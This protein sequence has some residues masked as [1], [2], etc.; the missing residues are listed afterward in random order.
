LVGL[1]MAPRMFTQGGVDSDVPL[2]GRADFGAAVVHALSSM[3]ASDLSWLPFSR[4]RSRE[5]AARTLHS[6]EHNH[7]EDPNASPP[8]VG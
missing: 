3:I 1:S 2:C 5:N 4:A 8:V 7:A 6:I